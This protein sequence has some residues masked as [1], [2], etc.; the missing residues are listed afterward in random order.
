MTIEQL[1]TALKKRLL[2]AEEVAQCLDR[3]HTNSVRPG[4]VG[5]SDTHYALQRYQERSVALSRWKKTI[6]DMEGLS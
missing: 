6:R 2:S 3:L 1:L 5:G 4:S